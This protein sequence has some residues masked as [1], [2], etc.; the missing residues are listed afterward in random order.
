MRGALRLRR[1]RTSPEWLLLVGIVTTLVVVQEQYSS[2]FVISASCAGP[3]MPYF[4]SK[5]LAPS[6]ARFAAIFRATVSDGSD[7]E[8]SGGLRTSAERHRRAASSSL[9]QP[10]AC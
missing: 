7:M 6:A 2:I 5:R 4:R 8:R 9:R 10:R 1:G 3:P